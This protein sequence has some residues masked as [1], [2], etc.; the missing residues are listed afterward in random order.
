MEGE[1]QELRDLVAHLK[2]DNERLRQEQAPTVV[3]PGVA[4]IAATG[5]SVVQQP[6]GAS[7]QL[8]ERFI[9][10]PRDR[11]CPMFSGRSS[12]TI[13]EWVDEAQACMR[14]CHLSVVDQAFFLFDHL[15]G[16]AQDEIRYHSDIER[17]DPEKIIQALRELYGCSLSY[18]ALQQ[19]FF[20]RR[21]QEGET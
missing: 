7:A 12:L 21:Q 8:S 4:T 13:N 17:G 6:T 1:L 14:A 19:A 15:K 11:K 18:V 3:D 10:V 2:A 16:E 9:F 20:S 5:P